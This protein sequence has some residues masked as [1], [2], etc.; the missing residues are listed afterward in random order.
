[1]VRFCTT[2][3]ILCPNSQEGSPTFQRKINLYYFTLIEVLVV[4]AIIALLFSIIMPAL[5]RATELAYSVKCMSNQRN[6]GTAYSQYLND[7]DG[8]FLDSNLIYFSKGM[9]GD[10]PYPGE[11]S[12]GAYGVHLRWCNGDVN[13]SKHPEYAGPLYSYITT[14]R[15]F[16]CPVFET[17]AT[18]GSQD[19]FYANYGS[20]IKNYEPWFNYTVNAYLGTSYS[21]ELVSMLRSVPQPSGTIMFTEESSA[22]DPSYNIAGLNDTAFIPGVGTDASPFWGY[23]MIS[24]WLRQPT[25][26]GDWRLIK[27]GPGVAPIFWDVIA[28]FH[29]SPPDAPL[30]GKGNCTFIDGHTSSCDREESF[31]LSY[32]LR[33]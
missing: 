16:I 32:P 1:M 14:P 29:Y 8:H 5:K 26:N 7:Y 18:K 17:L 33:K 6:L 20:A 30:Y 15:S 31:V 25:V 23:K 22:L 3:F 28:G 10:P 4:I 21:G 19:I 27:P 2:G 9:P 24:D 13:L 12:L 11:E